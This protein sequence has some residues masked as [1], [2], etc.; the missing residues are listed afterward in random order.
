MGAGA[1]PDT[2]SVRSRK[3]DTGDAALD[4][5][6]V[7]ANQV[8]ARAR[9]DNWSLAKQAELEDFLVA[10][11]LTRENVDE[12]ERAIEAAENEKPIQ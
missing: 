9:T 12:L 2:V 1:W 11:E 10:T 6:R 4:L 7:V 5:R 3:G 8:A